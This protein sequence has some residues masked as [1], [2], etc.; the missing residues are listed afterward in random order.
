MDFDNDT[1]PVLGVRVVL[2]LNWV[3]LQD[4]SWNFYQHTYLW[5]SETQG[6][7]GWARVWPVDLENLITYQDTTILRPNAPID[8]CGEHS[9]YMLEVSIRLPEDQQGLAPSAPGGSGRLEMADAQVVGSA[10]REETFDITGRRLV[11]ELAVQ[12]A[13]VRIVAGGRLVLA[14]R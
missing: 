1:I 14:V 12:G 6:V 7:V 13:G 8:W 2:D 9:N 3:L 10:G 5:L 11:A 4:R